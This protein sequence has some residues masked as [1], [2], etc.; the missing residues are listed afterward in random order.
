MFVMSVFCNRINTL[1]RIMESIIGQIN[2]QSLDTQ[3]NILDYLVAKLNIVKT[4]ELTL[5]SNEEHT[6]NINENENEKLKITLHKYFTNYDLLKNDMTNVVNKDELVMAVIANNIYAKTMKVVREK[7]QQAGDKK[8]QPEK[9]YQRFMYEHEHCMLRYIS[10]SRYINGVLIDD[11]RKLENADTLYDIPGLLETINVNVDKTNEYESKLYFE[12]FE[13][14][15]SEYLVL[16]QF[17]VAKIAGYFEH[18][19]RC[20]K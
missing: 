14:S 6:I 5:K 3:Q 2:Q 16:L 11:F 9:Y 15:T 19:R 20:L 13:K 18:S 10:L 8:T 1:R 4:R 7:S 12:S 17:V